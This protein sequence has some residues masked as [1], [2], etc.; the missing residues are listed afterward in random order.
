MRAEPSIPRSGRPAAAPGPPSKPP[1]DPGPDR[2]GPGPARV[3]P[4]PG[5]LPER[6]QRKQARHVP[7][8]TGTR[9]GP[10]ARK[11]THRSTGSANRAR[12]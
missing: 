12:A 10:P 11:A 9:A 7:S 1:D 2:A 3:R 5:P 8:K 4:G 6:P